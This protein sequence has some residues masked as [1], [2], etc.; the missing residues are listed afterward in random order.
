MRRP[1]LENGPATP[2]RLMEY[3]VS[4]LKKQALW[5]SLL[6]FFFPFLVL[7]YLTIFLYRSAWITQE[8]L[9]FAGATVFGVALLLGILRHRQMAP[10]LRFAAR[11][12]DER[13][14]GK[15]RFVTLATIDLSL[16]PAFLVARLRHEAAGLLHR[17]DLKKDFPYL[18]KRSFFASLI[19]SLAFI[20]L[21]HLI[22]QIGLLSQPQALPVKELARLAQELSQVP[23]FSELARS[24]EA[25]AVRMKEPALPSAEKRFL[26]EE[27]LKKVESQLAAERQEGGAGSDLL[28]QAANALRGMGQGTEKGQEQRGGGGLKTNLPEEREGRGNESAKGSGEGEEGEFTSLGSKDFKGGK[29]GQK[30]QGV[31]KGEGEGDQGRGDK[32]KGERQ[33]ETKGMAKGEPEGKGSK[34]KWEEIPRGGA[35]ERFL[36]PGEQGDQGIKGARFVTVELPE[37]ETEGSAREGGSGKR[38][39]LRP[40]V[41]VGNVPLRRPDSPD[42]SPEK[43]PLPLEYRGLIR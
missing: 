41:P 23:R 17:I 11:L 12:I 29:S 5:D 9:I 2:E 22:L 42:A 26:V 15:D 25:M 40:K 38:R 32:P 30:E 16:C 34:S 31:G 37:A 3:L 4:H 24:L 14:E 21:F 39:E 13:V 8:T 6:I 10:S 7:F 36:Q 19:G 28:S 1:A 35:P 33:K 20:L 18:I 27:M 43:Q